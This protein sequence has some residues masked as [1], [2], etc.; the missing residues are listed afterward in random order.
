MFGLTNNEISSIAKTS[1]LNHD[2]FVE[3]DQAS[4]R[5][6]DTA[7][8]IHP[9]LARTLNNGPRLRLKVS[10]EGNCYFLGTKGCVLPRRA[11]P[12]FCRMFPVFITPQGELAL[13]VSETCLAQE[14]AESPEEVLSRLGQTEKSLRTLHARMLRMSAAH[15]T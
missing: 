1:G 14:G 2:E 3:K 7:E 13:M 6:I 12:I 8:A 15:R 5:L 9:A 11:R 4:P 10:A